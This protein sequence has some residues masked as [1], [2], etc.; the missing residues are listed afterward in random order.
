[1]LCGHRKMF[2]LE[3]SILWITILLHDIEIAQVLAWKFMS[4][5]G[6][7]A[8]GNLKRKIRNWLTGFHKR[9]LLISTHHGTGKSRIRFSD[10]YLGVKTFQQLEKD[11]EKAFLV[12]N[13]DLT[14]AGLLQY[15][16][17]RQLNY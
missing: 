2:H 17:E 4:F 11:F 16:S 10:P 14:S 1:M 6:N 12:V 7:D 15:D 13:I 5:E 9:Y 8:S 3:A